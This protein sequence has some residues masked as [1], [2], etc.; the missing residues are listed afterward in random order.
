MGKGDKVSWCHRDTV[1]SGV[2]EKVGTFLGQPA[3]WVNLGPT[4][5]YYTGQPLGDTIEIVDLADLADRPCRSWSPA[6]KSE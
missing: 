3:V 6:E 2:V 1:Y 4:Y 5:D